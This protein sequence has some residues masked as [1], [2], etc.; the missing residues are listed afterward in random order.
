MI[1]ILSSRK[2]SVYCLRW[3]F[4][5]R[6]FGE[7]FE[8]KRATARSAVGNGLRLALMSLALV[9]ILLLFASCDHDSNKPESRKPSAPD[10]FSKKEKPS[11]VRDV[12]VEGSLGSPFED[13]GLRLQQPVDVWNLHSPLFGRR[14]HA[15]LVLENKRSFPIPVKVVAV[16]GYV[17]LRK[18]TSIV[19]RFDEDEKGKP[20]FLTDTF[21]AS[22]DSPPEV[23]RDLE[24]R[25]VSL[26]PGK[27]LPSIGVYLTDLGDIDTLVVIVLRP[28]EGQSTFII[29]DVGKL[30]NKPGSDL[31]DD[32]K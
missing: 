25:D 9:A 15:F 14:P 29:R 22:G 27:Q 11:D 21:D 6:L 5:E 28:G 31:R 23:P 1:P 30:Y 26:L 18:V 20:H 13:R 16:H 19:G 7:S 10:H 24:V 12:V 4:F 8:V 17:G 32:R 2:V 3:A